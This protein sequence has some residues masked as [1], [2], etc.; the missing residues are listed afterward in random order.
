MDMGERTG[1]DI[2][3]EKNQ[4]STREILEWF[5]YLYNEMQK[6]EQQK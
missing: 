3:S 5:E 4:K 1:Y 2:R 6:R